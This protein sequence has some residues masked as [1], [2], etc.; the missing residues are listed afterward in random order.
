MKLLLL[1]FC[2]IFGT[3]AFLLLERTATSI[4]TFPYNQIRYFLFIP[5]LILLNLY[6]I[7]VSIR[8]NI[9][10][11][12]AIII[13]LFLLVF[14]TK[15]IEIRTLSYSYEEITREHMGKTEALDI[16]SCQL[17]EEMENNNARIIVVCGEY[18]IFH[19]GIAALLPDK[20]VYNASHE[21]QSDIYKY[22]LENNISE[23]VL[24]VTY[25]KDDNYFNI[26]YEFVNG[27]LIDYI[28]KEKGISQT[29]NISTINI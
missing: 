18:E 3:L 27:N 12:N 17:A 11:K 13:I 16:I 1:N 21:R 4:Y 26:E 19:Y 24:F 25:R 6:F 28:E 7:S 5:Y 20:I 10:I 2:C 9:E 29:I 14:I 8:K 23:N 15:L 22:L